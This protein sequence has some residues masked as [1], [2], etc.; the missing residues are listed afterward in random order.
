MNVS[1]S[2]PSLRRRAALL[3]ASC[4]AFGLVS[5]TSVSVYKVHTGADG[6]ETVDRSVSGLRFYRP[7]P[8]VCVHEPFPISAQTYLAKGRLT[9][10]GKYVVIEE[11]PKG[12]SDLPFVQAGAVES[13]RVMVPGAGTGPSAQGDTTPTPD[14]KK[15]D[16]P[17]P[18]PATPATQPS[19]G[20]IGVKSTNDPN[21]YSITPA[22]RYF[23]VMYL[24]DFDENYVVE[25]R[26]GLGNATAAVGL[27]QGWSLQSLD[28][29]QDNSRIT[30]PLLDLFGDSL[31]M[32]TELGKRSLGIPP[33]P[34]GGPA[35]QGDTGGTAA[36]E[37]KGGQAVT[38]RLTRV[39]LVAPG[40]Y[41][42][43]KPHEQAK[44]ETAL[45]TDR[46]ATAKDDRLQQMHLPLLNATNIAFNVY[47]TVLIEA[48]PASGDSTYRLLQYGGATPAGGGAAGVPAADPAGISDEQLSAAVAAEFGGLTVSR[49]GKQFVVKV[50]AGRTLTP[51]EV[52]AVRDYIRGNSPHAKGAP[53]EAIRFDPPQPPR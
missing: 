47:E 8:Y 9:P 19:S 36:T 52:K 29:R 3:V 15:P 14:A 21:A 45:A 12:L 16:A 40:L 44:L 1:F 41:P 26:Q 24:P 42:I 48:V 31:K 11:L 4:A 17:A 37:F 46:A 53:D 5:C 51:A 28:A 10:D 43:L 23:D 35:A 18:A 33:I 7:R 20:V 25:V 6:A 22:R 38:I 27:G 34:A 2:S 30:E 49:D 32:L 13:T 39:K 50:P